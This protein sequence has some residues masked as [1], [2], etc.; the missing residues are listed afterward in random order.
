M[1]TYTPIASQTLGS[2]AATVTFSSI[3]QNYTDL[4]L[5]V[6]A[7]MSSGAGYPSFQLNGDTTDTNYSSTYIRGD[8][9]DVASGRYSG[10][11]GKYNILVDIKKTTPAAYIIINFQNYSNSATYKTVLSRMG[12]TASGTAATVAMWR[13]TN[14]INRITLKEATGGANWV[15]GSTFTL[16]GVTAGNSSAKASGGN[17]VT[18]DGT[19]WYHTFTSSGV[20]TPSSALSADVLVVAGGG[21]GG[22]VYGGGGGGGG[23]CYQTGRSLSANSIYTTVI[24]AGGASNFNGANSVFDTITAIGGGSGGQSSPTLN[25]TSGG[26]GG[27][28]EYINYVIGT[29]T[30]GNSGGATGFGFNGGGRVG[31]TNY[32]VGGGGGGAGGAGG[33]GNMTTG[34]TGTGGIGKTYSISGTSIGYA[35]G[36]GGARDNSGGSGGSASDGGGAGSTGSGLGTSGTANRGGGGG[37]G[38]LPPGA[39]RATGGRGGSGIVIVRYA[40]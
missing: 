4:I 16:Y 36:G 25:A 27:G 40:V 28:G 19:Y 15:T 1:S 24:G 13:D 12:D 23:L 8:G 17:I 22:G 18:T 39:S 2:A 21:G 37:G 34:V 33:D 6:D 30:Q 9:T 29:A 31:S 14:A 10:A 5:V 38:G 32:A 7:G 3:P 20:F 35:G 26:S 11:S